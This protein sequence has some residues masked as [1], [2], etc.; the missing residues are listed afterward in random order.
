MT[1]LNQKIKCSLVLIFCKG[2]L[3]ILPEKYFVKSIISTY[4]KE[5]IAY[6]STT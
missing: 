6:T 3:N 5:E 1:L 2:V 4:A